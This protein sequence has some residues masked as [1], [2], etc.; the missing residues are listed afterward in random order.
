MKEIVTVMDYLK[1]RFEEQTHKS[2]PTDMSDDMLM[3][4][5]IHG[6]TA[7]FAYKLGLGVLYQIMKQGTFIRVVLQDDV[8]SKL[9]TTTSPITDEVI[10]TPPCG[11]VVC[12]ADDNTVLTQSVAVIPIQ[13]ET[14]L[15]MMRFIKDNHL[16]QIPVYVSSIFDPDV[17]KKAID[18]GDVDVDANFPIMLFV[19]LT[20]GEKYTMYPIYR[21][22]KKVRQRIA[23]YCDETSM[24]VMDKATAD[25]ASW[26]VPAETIYME[27]F[28]HPER[29]DKLK[30]EDIPTYKMRLPMALQHE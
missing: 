24:Q 25:C 11:P 26:V 2:Y 20:P 19:N 12:V 3:F 21:H 16:G 8:F 14:A 29:F 23:S 28:K 13:L 18:D 6:V 17:Y 4:N 9:T 22:A 30:H 27:W 5:F 7:P 1:G 15:S 10:T